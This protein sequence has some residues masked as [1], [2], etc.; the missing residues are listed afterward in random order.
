VRERIA[1]DQLLMGYMHK[2]ESNAPPEKQDKRFMFPLKVV[3]FE[4]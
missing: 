3:D 4:Q 1:D 2:T